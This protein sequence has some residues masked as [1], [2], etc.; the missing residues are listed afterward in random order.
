M[1]ALVRLAGKW[2]LY[3]YICVQNFKTNV[4]YLRSGPGPAL[5]RHYNGLLKC[6]I[7]FIKDIPNYKEISLV[8]ARDPESRN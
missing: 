1:P 3:F 4:L 6:I 8:G 7:F 5:A 2:Q